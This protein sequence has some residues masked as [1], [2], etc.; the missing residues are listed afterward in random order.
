MSTEKYFFIMALTAGAVTIALRA[1]PFLMFS[2]SRP[3]P[4]L[5]NYIGKVL[6]PAA[7]AMLVI[8]CYCSSYKGK[9]FA[10]G[11]WGLP[12]LAAS[13]VVVILQKWKRN[14]LL[15]IIAGTAVYML[16]IQWVFKS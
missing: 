14:P 5:I 15:S 16:M 8:Y 13:A 7:I 4:P 10:A 3:V 2:R 11:H 1:F 12:E 6:P 9:T